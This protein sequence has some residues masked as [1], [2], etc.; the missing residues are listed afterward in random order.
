MKNTG[1][2]GNTQVD[3]EEDSIFDITGTFHRKPLPSSNISFSSQEGMV[4]FQEAM[5]EGNISTPFFDLIQAFQTQGYYSFC[6]LGSLT[7]ALNSLLIDPKRKIHG[8]W[9]WFDESM[10]NC[11]DPIER[12]KLK[13]ISL[14][15]L[16][17]LARCQGASSLLKFASDFTEDSLRAD[18]LSV[19]R[20]DDRDCNDNG[21]SSCNSSSGSSSSSTSSSS[22]SSNRCVLIASYD[23][24]VLGQTGSGHFSPIGGYHA[25]RDL[26]L[27]LDAARFKY[28]PHW[29]KLA[30]L[31]EA[32]LTEDE[33]T[34]KSRGYLLVARPTEEGDSIF[35]EMKASTQA[36]DNHENKNSCCSGDK[37]I[38][39]CS[40]SCT[41]PNSSSSSI[42]ECKMCAAYTYRKAAHDSMNKKGTAIKGERHHKDDHEDNSD[43]DTGQISNK[44]DNAR[45]KISVNTDDDGV[46]S[47]FIATVD[48]IHE[49]I[50]H[51]YKKRIKDNDT[52]IKNYVRGIS[53]GVGISTV[54]AFIFYS[55][56]RPKSSNLTLEE[57]N[58]LRIPNSW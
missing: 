36:G 50:H 55:F 3:M 9:R 14:P 2:R 54:V 15:K 38:R 8:I 53:M 46:S 41:A 29:I 6:G 35:E 19:V 52:V 30:T 21:S 22:G 10:L 56:Q 51:V 57:M 26:V 32:M 20:D 31:Y 47:S 37:S 34:K 13:G 17:C 27:I 11:C 42:H 1:I 23:R 45:G 18:I 44:N 43:N 12:V 39:N 16:H 5:K 49:W 7:M 24:R 40:E 28:P 25:G 58:Q 48:I 4:I 33:E